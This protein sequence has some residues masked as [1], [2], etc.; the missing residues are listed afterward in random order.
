MPPMSGMPPPMPPSRHAA[1]Q[2]PRASHLLQDGHGNALEG[3]LLL[4][5]LLLLGVWLASSHEVVSSMAS[6]E[7]FLS[8][9]GILSLTSS[10][11]MES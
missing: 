1:R 3:L 7:A 4:L 11:S 2:P 5:E 9:S 6:S 8:S 10:P